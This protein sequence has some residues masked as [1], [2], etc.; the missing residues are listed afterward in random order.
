MIKS[1]DYIIDGNDCWIWQLSISWDGYGRKDSQRAHRL[2]Y[3]KYK[4]KI[5]K[6][7]TLDHLCRKRD[8]VNPEH[9]EIV[10]IAENVR[11][12]LRSKVNHKEAREIRFLYRLGGY[13]QQ[14]LGKVYGLG[15]S[16]ISRIINKYNWKGI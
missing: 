8:C 16:A 7:L 1:T 12:G 14:E 3:E 6:G 15:Q 5:P 2:Y 13:T 9:L 10:T 4:G 11:R